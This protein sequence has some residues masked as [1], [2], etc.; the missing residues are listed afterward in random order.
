MVKKRRYIK[1][2]E[3]IVK[4]KL[5][6]L[7]LKPIFELSKFKK[8]NKRFYSTPCFDERGKKVFLKILIVNEISPNEAIR[9]EI[10]I[11][12]FL[13]DFKEKISYPHLIKFDN[14]NFPYWFISQYLEGK[15]LGSFYNLYSNN[16]K[17]IPLLVNNLF[18]LQKI[19]KHSIKKIAKI[20]NAH[21]WKRDFRQYLKLVKSYRT[22]IEKGI[23]K[24]I[25]FSKIYQLFKEKRILLEKS[26]LFLSHGDFTLANFVTSKKGIVITT[27]WEQ[28][29]LDNL[30]YDI[31][32]LWI[33][34]WRYPVWQKKLISEFISRLSKRK[35][36][37]FKE[38]FRI[39]IISEALG[40]LRWTINLCER[41]YRKGAI[42]A[43][44]KII[45]AS[46]KGFNNLL[47]L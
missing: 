22:G 41:K 4:E 32:H 38:I 44:F 43:N 18:S 27:D 36:E 31:S 15:L 47:N 28:A 14:K 8:T 12:K 39:I 2:I 29:H 24:K 40:E 10:E 30:A 26:P 6:K 13:T 23:S 33:Q 17:Y 42:E 37:E 5:Q 34:L 35:R 20:K 11:R 25:N 19:P 9:R 1:N 45:N 21:L 3:G 7:Q 16:K 46:L